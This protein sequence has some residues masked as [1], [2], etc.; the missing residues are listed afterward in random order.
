MN[1]LP[2]PKEEVRCL[3]IYFP[4]PVEVDLS[5]DCALG[6]ISRMIKT[7]RRHCSVYGLPDTQ[8]QML[9]IYQMVSGRCRPNSSR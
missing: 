8:T 2:E 7:K 9:L 1:K 6:M 3:A 4:T 5:M